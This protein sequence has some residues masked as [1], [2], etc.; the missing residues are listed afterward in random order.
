MARQSPPGY[1]RKIV[2][3]KPRAYVTL[4][5]S[6]TG[7]RRDVYLGTYGSAESRIQYAHVLADWEA[8]GRAVPLRG[9]AQGRLDGITV[10][11]LAE[12][13]C[14]SIT[15][16]YSPSESRLLDSAIRV[17]VEYCGSDSAESFVAPRLIRLREA[18]ICG[19]EPTRRPWGRKYINA[20]VG[21]IRR[22]VRWGVAQ[23]LLPPSVHQSLLAVEHLRPGQT[24][25]PEPGP[26]KPAPL[27]HVRA[28]Q[29][30]VSRQIAAM[31]D[32]QLLTGM[33]PGEVCAIRAIDLDMEG[34]TWQYQPQ[35]HKMSYRGRVRTIW[36]GP[37][38]QAVIRPYLDRAID[39]P[40]F[41]PGEAAGADEPKQAAYTADSYRRAI[42]RA[43]EAAG[44]DVWHPHQLR[45]TYATAVRRQY[46]LEAAQLL[47]GHSSAALTDAV[48]AER[49]GQKAQKIAS[50]IG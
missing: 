28:A 18:M 1:R 32:V 38:A 14:Q 31:I 15:G 40:I 6:G 37:Q 7:K 49:D 24:R 16:R 13:Y 8:A 29:A 9:Q 35:R 43:C 10:A 45:H 21:R 20:Q 46:G 47:L 41:S 11:Q 42:R 26:I 33:R 19:C 48:Y 25:K 22:I 2:R 50:E 34:A 17:W 39:A 3:G 36:L 44:V 4:T 5:D 12:A 30:R 27:E 23:G